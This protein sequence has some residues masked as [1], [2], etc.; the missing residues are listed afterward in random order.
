MGG[1]NIIQL[2]RR[3]QRSAGTESVGVKGAFG[4]T[5][6]LGRYTGV[7]LEV[8]AAHHFAS[9]DHLDNQESPEE[10]PADASSA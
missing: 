10:A 3:K 2:S 1:L 7:Y 6:E 4:S 5:V 8:R 9:V